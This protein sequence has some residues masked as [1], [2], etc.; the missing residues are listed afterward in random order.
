MTFNQAIKT[1][2]VASTS[3]YKVYTVILFI[4][5][6]LLLSAIKHLV[7][8]WNLMELD[9]RSTFSSLKPSRLLF[10]RDIHEHG[11]LIQLWRKTIFLE[12]TIFPFNV[13]LML[14]NDVSCVSDV[15]LAADVSEYP[16]MLSPQYKSSDE[17]ERL[18]STKYSFLN[19]CYWFKQLFYLLV[20]NFS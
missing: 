16:S 9:T 18:S 1:Q 15:L 6:I 2:E 7:I 19:M 17:M 10:R 13:Y 14:I 3:F 11:E 8:A 4:L 12:W 20:K 5:F